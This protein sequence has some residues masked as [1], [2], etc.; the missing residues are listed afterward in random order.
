MAADPQRRKSADDA[1]PVG[2]RRSLSAPNPGDQGIEVDDAL[3]GDVRP[4]GEGAE[5]VATRCE[6]IVERDAIGRGGIDRLAAQTHVED[7]TASWL[8]QVDRISEADGR[9]ER[10]R[11]GEAGADR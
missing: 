11:L 2:R 5:I 3:V 8:R 1:D 4:G 9:S 10:G 7:A 6:V